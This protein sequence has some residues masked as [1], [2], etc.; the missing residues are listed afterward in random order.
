MRK[1]EEWKK[2]IKRQEE[3]RTYREN[4]KKRS[5]LNGR[6]EGAG[7]KRNMARFVFECCCDSDLMGSGESF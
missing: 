4:F 6:G 7:K 5:T 1:L 2:K 3:P